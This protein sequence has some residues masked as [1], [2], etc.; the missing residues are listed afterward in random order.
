[1]DPSLSFKQPGLAA[2]ESNRPDPAFFCSSWNEVQNSWNYEF[3]NNPGT[4]LAF[5]DPPVDGN[6]VVYLKVI[7]NGRKTVAESRIQILVGDA[8]AIDDDDD[9]DNDSDGSGSC[10]DNDGDSDS[11]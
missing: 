1:V 2:A 5:F 8:S 11:D 4:S 7:K 6:Y 9:S 10:S 3:F